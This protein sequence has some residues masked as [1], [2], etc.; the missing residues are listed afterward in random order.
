ME[1]PLSDKVR[2]VGSLPSAPGP[3]FSMINPHMT[4]GVKDAGALR[5]PRHPLLGQSVAP[6]FSQTLL[7]AELGDLLPQG[8]HFGNAMRAP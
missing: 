5:F 4:I 2:P 1:A 7:R 6:A 3:V 8:A